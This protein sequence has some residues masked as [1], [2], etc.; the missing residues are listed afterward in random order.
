LLGV[1]LLTVLTTGLDIGGINEF[2]QQMVTGVVLVGAVL[3][4]RLRGGS[5]VFLLRPF[6]NK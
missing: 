1:V 2:V 3:V 4:A 6:Q 5:F